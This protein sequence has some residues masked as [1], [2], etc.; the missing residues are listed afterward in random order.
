MDN[1]IIAIKIYLDA[2]QKLHDEKILINRHSFTNQIGE[3]LVETIYDGQRAKS[4]IQAGWDVQANGK[5]IQVKTHSKATS[6]DSN[7]TAI[8]SE[9][10]TRIDELIIINFSPEYKILEFYKIPWIEAIQHIKFSGKKNP[11]EELN[12]SQIKLFRVDISTLP[13]QDIITFFKP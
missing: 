11:R 13:R 10:K 12:W 4:G 9:S 3:W 2:L 7:F 5:N 1:K 6:N 8:S